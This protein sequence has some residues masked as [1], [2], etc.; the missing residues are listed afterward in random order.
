MQQHVNHAGWNDHLN[1]D[2]DIG[3]DI[4]LTWR[5]AMCFSMEMRKFTGSVYHKIKPKYMFIEIINE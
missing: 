5:S 2:I 1:D 4:I 3:I